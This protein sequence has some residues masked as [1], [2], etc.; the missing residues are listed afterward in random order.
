MVVVVH[1]DDPGVTLEPVQTMGQRAS[2][3]ASMRLERVRV[4]DERVLVASDGVSAAQAFLNERRVLLVCGPLG[5][6]QALYE[7]LVEDV[8]SSIRYGQPVSQLGSVQA[9]LGQLGIAIEGAR[10]LC[11][12]ALEHMRSDAFDPFFDRIVSAAKHDATECSVQVAMTALRLGGGVAYRCDRPYERHLRDFCGFISGGGTQDV[13]ESNI[14][15]Q[16]IAAHRHRQ[17]KSRRMTNEGKG[18]GQHEV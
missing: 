1:R 17:L 10:A 3:L 5:R 2:G 15:L 6:T 16:A 13:L 8:D 11:H 18:E 12:R 7:R 9:Q 14:G 4:E